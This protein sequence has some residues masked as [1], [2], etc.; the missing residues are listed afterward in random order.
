MKPFSWTKFSD[1]LRNVENGP[2]ELINRAN[3]I[4][5]QNVERADWFLLDA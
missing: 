5:K 3:E 1:M 4:S 2:N